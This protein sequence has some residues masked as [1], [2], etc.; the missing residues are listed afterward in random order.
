[1][2][3]YYIVYKLIK[4]TLPL[5]LLMSIGHGGRDRLR[6]ETSEKY[7]NITVFMIILFLSIYEVCNGKK[8]EKEVY[9]GSPRSYNDIYTN[10]VIEN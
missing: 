3:K 2:T 4:F 6:K 8:K 5:K 1:M 10:L 7:A 9:N